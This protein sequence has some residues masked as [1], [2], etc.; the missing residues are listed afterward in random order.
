MEENM[1]TNR[2]ILKVEFLQKALSRYSADINKLNMALKKMD[3]P[4]GKYEHRN[5][6]AECTHE[7]AQDKT[8]FNTAFVAADC[9]HEMTQD[10]NDLNTAFVAADCVHEM[11]QDKNDLNTAF[12]A[13]DSTHEMTQA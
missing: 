6:A 10:K 11:T 8:N 1:N 9:A 3:I 12:L 13:A 4:G 7:M 2:D 5:A